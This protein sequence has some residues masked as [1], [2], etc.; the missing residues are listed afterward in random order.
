MAIF[1]KSKTLETPKKAKKDERL[2]VMVAGIEAIASMDA[3]I[4]SLKAIQATKAEE[5]KKAMAAQ[6]IQLGTKSKSRPDNFR[7]IEGEASASCELRARASSSS[8]TDAEIELCAK[9]G[10][11]TTTVTSTVETFAINPKYLE[12]AAVMKAVEAALKKVKGLPEDFI[13]FQEGSF[14]TIIAEGAI[15]KMFAE[16]TAEQCVE[17]LPLVSTLA[18]TPKMDDEDTGMDRAILVVKN[19]IGLDLAAKKAKKLSK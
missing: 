16:K 7:G 15:E 4:K 14:K 11:A 3:V 12:D 19:L 9:Y 10:V 6:F 2:K 8:L 17:I 13:Q 1:D 5:V 18:I